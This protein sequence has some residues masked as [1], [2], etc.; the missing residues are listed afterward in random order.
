MEITTKKEAEFIAELDQLSLFLSQNLYEGKFYSF[1]DTLIVPRFLHKMISRKEIS[2]EVNFYKTKLNLPIISSPMSFFGEKFAEQLIKNKVLYSIPRINRSIK[3]RLK[4]AK[5]LNSSEYT[6]FSIGSKESD[7]LAKHIYKIKEYSKYI[8]IDIAHGA[9]FHSVH[10]LRTLKALGVTNNV[11]VGNIA[12][13]EGFLYL[14]FYLNE[15]GFSNAIIRVGIGSGS[16]CT[17]RLKTGVGFPQLSILRIL[18]E[19][20]SSLDGDWIDNN[21]F[22][23]LYEIFS[24][25]S[26][27]VDDIKLIADGGIK[28]E[29]DLAKAL[30]YSDLVMLG[31]KLISKEMDTY[32]PT[33]NSVHYFGMASAYVGKQENIEGGAYVVQNPPS[34][35]MVLQNVRDALTSSLSYVNAENIDQFRRLAVLVQ[36]TPSV[37]KENTVLNNF[38]F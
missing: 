22:P 11:I 36:T 3:D 21:K 31:K 28:E 16:A 26:I 19:L 38:S 37:T 8:L 33:T 1:E 5:N 27:P 10:T 7:E 20:K 23:A 13:V 30:I 12:S 15:L 17:T 9:S 25:L 34:L 4:L 2:T 24:N 29:G 35:K 6:V 18:Y 14:L 32:D